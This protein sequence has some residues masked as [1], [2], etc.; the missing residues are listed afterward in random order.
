[1]SSR[2]SNSFTP[3]PDARLDDLTHEE[4]APLTGLSEV[5]RTMSR[6]SSNRTH[7][8]EEH[9]KRVY[10][11]FWLLGAV[12]LLSWNGEVFVY[13]RRSILYQC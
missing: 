6:G 1:M 10:W 3:E 4:T 9:T 7:S 11:S 13:R 12:I 5:S 8:S 2:L